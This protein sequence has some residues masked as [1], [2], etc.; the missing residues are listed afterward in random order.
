MTPYLVTCNN[1]KTDNELFRFNCKNCGNVLHNKIANI[2]VWQSLVELLD[3]PTKAFIKIIYSERKNFAYL[4]FF[5]GIIKII[6]TRNLWTNLF[7]IQKSNSL[8]T[9]LFISIFPFVAFLSFMKLFSYIKKIKIR[10][11]DLFAL[12]GYG[13]LPVVLLSIILFPV[14]YGIFGNSWI[15]FLPSPF[16]LKTNI[17][18]LFVILESIMILIISF[19]IYFLFRI[20]FQ[21][22][23]VCILFSILLIFSQIMI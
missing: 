10:M 18:F 7:A 20:F 2:D 23:V 11:K 6:L 15:T 3:S 12:Y 19:Y 5:L 9:E 8:A 1:C 21:S 17:A 14:E 13:F 4:F 16:I 22:R